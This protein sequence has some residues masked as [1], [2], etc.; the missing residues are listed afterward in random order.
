M[1]PL[2]VS[3]LVGFLVAAVVVAVLVTFGVRRKSAEATRGWLPETVLSVRSDLDEGAVVTEDTLVEMQLPE[4]FVSLS[5]VRPADRSRLLGRKIT[6]PLQQGDP[7]MWQDFAPAE[8][9]H[10]AEACAERIAATVDARGNEERPKAVAAFVAGMRRDDRPG[11]LGAV[12][13]ASANRTRCVVASKDLN[14]GTVLRAEDLVEGQLPSLLATASDVP[15]EERSKLVGKRLVVPLQKGDAIMWQM[16]DDAAHP[17][18]LV[19]C[20]SVVVEAVRKARVDAATTA[21]KEAP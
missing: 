3:A 8:A 17:A 21:A 19:S 13:P 2:L 14:E 18:R 11:A 15:V 5:N 20:A 9:R 12:P 7:L 1:K 6:Q 16:L 4:Q 10:R